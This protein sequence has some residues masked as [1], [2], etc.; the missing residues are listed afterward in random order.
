M[1]I[2]TLLVL[3]LLM[4]GGLYA[5]EK[6]EPLDSLIVKAIQVSPKI[7][8]LKSKRNAAKARI[9]IGTNLPDP[10]LTLGLVNMPTN[11]FS[12]SQEPMTGKVIG[13][14]QAFPFPGGLKAASEVKAVDTLIVQEE[15]ED[16]KNKIREEVSKLYYDLRFYRKVIKLSEESE[17][18]LNKISEVVRRKFEVSKA[19]LQNV[20]QVEVEITRVKDKIENLKGKKEAALA[21][22]NALLL[23]D[24]KS[25]I[26]TDNIEKVANTHYS[27]KKLLDIASAYRPFLKGI[28]FA[29]QKSVNMKLQADYSFW[30]NFKLGVQYN[31]RDYSSASGQNW[32]DLF[33]VLLGVSLPINYGGNKSAKIN[34]AEHLQTLYKEQYSSSLQSL[35]R[36]FGKINAKLK[37]LR[38]RE[39]LIAGTLLPQAD[40]AL[41]AAMADYQVGKI[42]FV[43]VIKAEDQILKIKTD[44][45]KIR[46]EYSKDIAQL[47]FLIGAKITLNNN[48]KVNGEIR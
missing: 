33:S 8:M 22:L 12:F 44:L 34:E 17:E 16:Q 13:L 46:T 31:Q 21:E 25:P 11:S 40:D 27:T 18:L 4:F 6:V 47:E 32:S 37:E 28:K 48:D 39:K 1:K 35:S 10:V 14:S 29:E 24:E 45:A 41:E 42:D 30:P 36:S 20:I 2:R 3:S 26:A 43:N 19:S 15:L 38:E 5:Q 23:R 9:E 7:A